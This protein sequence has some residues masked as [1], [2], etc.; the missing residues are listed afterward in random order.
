MVTLE[1]ETDWPLESLR[2]LRR[3]EHALAARPEIGMG[4]TWVYQVQVN[5]IKPEKK[6]KSHA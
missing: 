5:V 1:I 3:W 2:V 6:Q 4:C